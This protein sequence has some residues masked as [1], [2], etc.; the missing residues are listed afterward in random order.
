VTIFF[1]DVMAITSLKW[2]HNWFFEVWF[3]HNL[4]EKLQFGQ[5][6]WHQLTKLEG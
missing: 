2:R 4:L 1:G 3:R 5:I 6:T